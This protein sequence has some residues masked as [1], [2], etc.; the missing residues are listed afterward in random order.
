MMK[1]VDEQKFKKI[2]YEQRYIYLF[3]SQR[4]AD[5]FEGKTWICVVVVLYVF[6]S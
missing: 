1:W 5:E 3:Y 2:Y 4:N 6:V